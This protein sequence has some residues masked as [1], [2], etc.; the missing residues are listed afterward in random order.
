MEK[1]LAPL[2]LNTFGG[3]VPWVVGQVEEDSSFIIFFFACFTYSNG[4]VF[5]KGACSD[6]ALRQRGYYQNLL[7]PAEK[8]PGVEL[9]HVQVDVVLL[10][11]KQVDLKDVTGH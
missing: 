5:I 4:A 10:A 11:A 3:W 7:I 1:V 8:Q 2:E 9:L 6:D